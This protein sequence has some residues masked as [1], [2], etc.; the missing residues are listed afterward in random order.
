MS[1]P[2]PQ[3]CENLDLVLQ[4]AC[5]IYSQDTSQYHLRRAI[6]RLDELLRKEWGY[7][8]ELSRKHDSWRG[9]DL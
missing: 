2:S 3:D 1:V 4:A 9:A 7:Q 6:D 5:Q 8:E